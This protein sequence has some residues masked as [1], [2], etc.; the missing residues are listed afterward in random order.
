VKPQI[1]SNGRHQLVATI[2]MAIDAH[3]PPASSEHAGIIAWRHD[4]D[5]A[6]S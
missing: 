5:T 1:L 3:Q 6:A 2:E 4:P